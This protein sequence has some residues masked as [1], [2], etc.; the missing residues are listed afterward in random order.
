MGIHPLGEALRF[1]MKTLELDK[2][3]TRLQAEKQE[4]VAEIERL[5]ETLRYELDQS[6][7]EGDPDLVEREKNLALLNNLER[8]LESIEEA[9]RMIRE[10]TYG[11]C[12]RCGQPIDPARLK[13]IPHARLCIRCQSEVE[14]KVRVA[15]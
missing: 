13:A 1:M 2:E 15:S 5:R 14:R 11:I 7:E 8:K 3:F 10:G 6:T 9:R 4:T 12:Q